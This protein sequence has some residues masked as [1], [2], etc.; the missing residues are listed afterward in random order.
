MKL[1]RYEGNFN[2]VFMDL[3]ETVFETFQTYDTSWTNF[4]TLY[5]HGGQEYWSDDFLLRK[6]VDAEP[7]FSSWGEEKNGKMQ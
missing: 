1:N 5:I 4:N 6:Y 3:T 2:F 7:Y